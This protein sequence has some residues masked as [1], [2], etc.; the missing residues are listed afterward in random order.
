MKRNKTASF[1]LIAAILGT[2]LALSCRPGDPSNRIRKLEKQRDALTQ[3]IDQL[4]ARLSGPQTTSG[5]TAEAPISVRVETVVPGVFRHFITVQGVVESDANILVPPLSPGLVKTIR[6][7]TGDRVAKGRI[8]AELDAAVL[9]SGIAEVEHGLVLAETIYERRARLWE[10][11][12]GSEIEFLQAK[13]NKEGLEKKL[14]TLQEQLNLTRIT[15]PI[16]GVVDEIM[17]KEGE[18]APAGFGAFRIVRMSGLKVK[19]SLSENY[20]G[21]VLRGDP[22][23][24]S[25]PVLG[26]EF[27]GRIDTVSQV[28]DARNRTFHVE[29]LLPAG[30][31]GIKP[32]MLAVLTI[33]DYT[34]P[35]ALTIPQNVVQETGAERFLFI[36]VDEGGRM[37]AVKRTVR[38][39]QTY[40]NRV[41][42]LE[43]LTSGDR[44]VTFGFQLVADGRPIAVDGD[45]R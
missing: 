23:G 13:N 31:P 36:A 44:V 29:V 24:I 12:I 1:A 26:R 38:I 42:I 33:N 22:V 11:K 41:E 37:N 40:D 15:A 10:K 18:M 19:A 28:I 2:T 27:E 39:G 6:V 8:L 4:K 35:D 32:N 20:V 9:E 7:K 34:N 43:G 45:S 30:E 5:R 3:E 25:I 14:A 17:I 21:R 16:D